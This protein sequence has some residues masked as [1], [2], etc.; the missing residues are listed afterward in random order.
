MNTKTDPQTKNVSLE[1]RER[2]LEQKG[3]IIWFT[4]LSGAGKTTLSCLLEK[5]NCLMKILWCT[6]LTGTRFALA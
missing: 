6:S 2:R 3:T 4:G 5:K 1:Q